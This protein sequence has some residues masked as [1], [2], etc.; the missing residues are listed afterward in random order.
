MLE[1]V[2]RDAGG[3]G[4]AQR[5]A[6]PLDSRP[7]VRW[8][9]RR[10]AVAGKNRGNLSEQLSSQFAVPRDTNAVQILKNYFYF[11]GLLWWLHKDSNLGP[12]H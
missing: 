4:L 7:A 6:A 9:S 10:G 11:K 5:R 12:A 2:D 3:L 1:R 8:R